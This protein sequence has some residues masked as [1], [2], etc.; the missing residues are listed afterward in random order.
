MKKLTFL[1]VSLLILFSCQQS[2]NLPSQSKFVSQVA[3]DSNGFTYEYVKNDPLNLRIYTLKNG[4]KVYLSQND[5]EPRATGIVGVNAGAK[6]DPRDNTGLAHYLEHLLFKGTTKIGTLD[7]NEEQK[8]LQQIE[9]LFEQRKTVTDS[10]K[11]KE[12]YHQI[13]SIS[14]LAS[15]YSAANEYDKLMNVI[16]AKYTNAST[17]PDMTMYIDNVP[18]NEIDRWLRIE[19]ERFGDPVFR[20]FHTELEAVYE[21]FNIGQSESWSAV[22]HAIA[23]SFYHYHPYRVP[24]IGKA[25]HLKNPSIKS[26]K[27]YFKKNYVPNNMVIALSGDLDFDKTI[28]E[29]N[30]YWGG[31][32]PSEKIVRPT[33]KKED[34]IKKHIDKE[35]FTQD[36]PYVNIAYRTKGSGSDDDIYYEMIDNLLSNG[37]AGLIDLNLEQSQKV[38][39]AYSYYE[40][41]DD[42]GS[43]ELGGSP[44]EGQTLEEVK[45]LLLQQIELIKQGKF[46]DGLIQAIVDNN[47]LDRIRGWERNWRVYQLVDIFHSK[48]PYADYLNRY[49]KMA[50]LRKV[51]IVKFANEHFKD[52]YVTVY[53]RQGKNKNL[54]RIDKPDITPI[55]IDRSKES[56]YYSEFKKEKVKDIEPVFVN[57]GDKMKI[58]QIEKGV[59]LDYIQNKNNDLFNLMFV[60]KT[61]SNADKKLKLAID[62]LPYVGTSTMSADSLKKLMFKLAVSIGVGTD[63]TKSYVYV[64]GL[65]KN[66]KPALKLFKQVLTDAKGDNESYANYVDGLLKERSDNKND[67]DFIFWDGLKDYAL[68]GPNNPVNYVLTEEDLKSVD[69]NTIMDKVHNLNKYPMNISYYG[70]MDQQLLIANLSSEKLFSDQR[71]SLPKQTEFVKK[72]IRQNTVLFV[73]YDMVQADLL[74]IS[75]DTKFDKNLRIASTMFNEYYGG[76]MSS[77]IFQEIRESKGLAY[78][79]YSNYSMSQDTS[80]IDMLYSYIG[81]QPDKIELASKTMLKLLNELP[82]AEDNF[83]DTKN[84]LKKRMR[85]ERYKFSDIFWSYMYAQQMGLK[86]DGKK[87]LYESIDNYKLADVKQFFNQHVKNKP[88][89]M[90][91]IGSKKYVDFKVLEEFGKVK[92]VSLK[93]LFPKY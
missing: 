37:K 42:Y 36:A 52:N 53:K 1:I 61:G 40:A 38:L 63:K 30:K 6:D 60:V 22:N 66:F 3:K 65:N 80:D 82:D 69:A 27:A 20:L 90:I 18:T 47:R 35:V 24:V 21:E 67:K 19:A 31:F 54:V 93:E 10:I 2:K 62:Y 58:S 13:D 68:Y 44:R 41:M 5:V 17:G 89:T 87:E 88:Y 84:G 34:P 8:Y 75:T 74:F 14:G 76:N 39:D 79:T 46:D 4:L 71:I 70:P 72:P 49:N 92:E 7:W 55:E 81:T 85:T 45:D 64:N 11:R 77:V 25:E 33:Y 59:E 57:F 43:V 78:S 15:K 12:L 91:V 51:D 73:D 28:A 56:K 9:D 16:G 32:K 29:V 50:Q 23:E 26:I 48:K 86:N 83:N